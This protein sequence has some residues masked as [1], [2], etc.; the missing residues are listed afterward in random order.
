MPPLLPSTSLQQP[1][2][3][4]KVKVI[5]SS[6]VFFCYLSSG[7]RWW[8]CCWWLRCWQAAPPE[9]Y[10]LHFLFRQ[11]SKLQ[12][13]FNSFSPLLWGSSNTILTLFCPLC[14]IIPVGSDTA[15]TPSSSLSS[16]FEQR[17]LGLSQFAFNSFQ[18]IFL[19]P[20]TI[21]FRR[22]KGQHFPGCITEFQI[23]E[24]SL[25]FMTIFNFW[26]M[27]FQRY[28]NML[29]LSAVGY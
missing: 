21:F 14:F 7:F 22:S 23:W 12:N 19:L 16:P 9:T 17:C 3:F 26:E 5:F 10:F 8:W 20:S 1:L 24:D 25:Q 4:F 6:N 27:F 2:Y 11:T 29:Q 15:T 28:K 18:E 13:L